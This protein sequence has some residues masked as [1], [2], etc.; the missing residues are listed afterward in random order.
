MRG[1]RTY[2]IVD[3]ER[4]EGTWR[5]IFIQ[6]LGYHLTD[7]LIFADGALWCWE[8]VDLDG[9]RAK[10]ESG[11]IATTLE[12]GARASAHHLA[13]WR[14]DE[15][16]TAFTP[17]TLLG[18]V[19]DEIDRLNGRPD[20]TA[21][22]RLAL[23]H[24]LE[25]RAEADRRA[26]R[27]AYLDIPE[28]LRTYALGD[29]DSKDGPLVAL[30]TDIGEPLITYRSSGTVPAA[31]ERTREHA[32]AYF[33]DRARAQE[34]YVPRR[35]ADDPDTAP[36]GALHIPERH[37]PNGW[38]ETPGP[39]V[40]Q[41]EYPAPITIASVTYPTV[42]HAYWALSTINPEIRDR[43]RR[44]ERP[45]DAGRLARDAPRVPGWPDARAAVMA[46]LLRTKFRTHPEL[47][48]VLLA[49]RD[50]PLHYGGGSD[51]WAAHGEKGRNWMGRLLELVRS[52]LHADM[53]EHMFDPTG[54]LEA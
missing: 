22:C 5:P 40:L 3:G 10:L 29:M 1:K 9:L 37:Y 44:A 53:I 21:R 34:A 48:E 16:R 28:H 30:C 20:S 51:Y 54:T 41:N 27:A 38:P 2:R 6:N 32:L 33:A 36:A 35:P 39:H 24:Y 11:W 15:P 25:T 47:A 46:R 42:H 19:A 13:S 17:E 4:I 52:E 49:T 23:D 18:E 26:L 7:L 43:V 14:F 50:A 12:P 31:T 45:F 8:W